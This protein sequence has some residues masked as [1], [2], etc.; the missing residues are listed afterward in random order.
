VCICLASQF[1]LDVC[2]DLFFVFLNNVVQQL[3]AVGS[4][5]V[6]KL[7]GFVIRYNEAISVS[8]LGLGLVISLSGTGSV[9]LQ[10]YYF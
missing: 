4:F 7:N 9:L 3:S 1:F 6:A 10:I 2:S 8:L 5:H